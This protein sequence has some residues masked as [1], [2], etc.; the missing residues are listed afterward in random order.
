MKE[1]RKDKNCTEHY[2]S[3]D[4]LRKAFGIK[5]VV[6]RTKDEEKLK[7]QREKFLGICKVCKQPLSLVEG[8]N[9]LACKNED[10]KGLP[11]KGTNED[12][13]EK[14]WYIPVSRILDDKGAEIARNLFD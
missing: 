8:C 10:C 5:P 12:G 1:F 7:A 9:V 2:T 14:I 6:K 4:E 11:M 13:S 3:F